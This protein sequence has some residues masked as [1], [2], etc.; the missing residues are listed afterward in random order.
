VH[1]SW[2]AL[3]NPVAESRPLFESARLQAATR[4]LEHLAEAVDPLQATIDASL[5]EWQYSVGFEAVR[6]MHAEVCKLLIR[7]RLPTL[8]GQQWVDLVDECMQWERQVCSLRFLCLKLFAIERLLPPP[9]C[10]CD[11]IIRPSSLSGTD[12][13]KLRSL[14]TS[15]RLQCNEKYF[16]LA[17]FVCGRAQSVHASS[18]NK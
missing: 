1:T 18:G 4:S 7:R 16:T 5:P 3:H 2:E 10:S 13:F 14:A 12:S 11:C 8:S 15:S 6:C 9:A 17:L